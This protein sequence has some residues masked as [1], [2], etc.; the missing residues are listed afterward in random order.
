MLDADTSVVSTLTSHAAGYLNKDLEKIDKYFYTQF[1]D[2]FQN[3]L[4]DNS[5]QNLKNV[6]IAYTFNISEKQY[7][8]EYLFD[9]Y[10]SNNA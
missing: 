6:L 4:G 10:I 7:I 8:L 5:Y 9:K 3:M 1:L 2:Y